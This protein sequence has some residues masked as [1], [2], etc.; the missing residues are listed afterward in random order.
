LSF[1]LD[2]SPLDVEEE[3]VQMG[4]SLWTVQSEED[5]REEQEGQEGGTSAS[6][7]GEPYESARLR[8]LPEVLS[9]TESQVVST[10]AGVSELES[11]FALVVLS[12][13]G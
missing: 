9:G 10:P 12:D 1:L 5:Y 7:I 8:P 4:T 6:G 11:V 3:R 13:L 2:P